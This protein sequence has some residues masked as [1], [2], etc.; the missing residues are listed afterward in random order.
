[1]KHKKMLSIP[2]LAGVLALLEAWPF[3]RRISTP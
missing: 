2:I 1:M 3:P